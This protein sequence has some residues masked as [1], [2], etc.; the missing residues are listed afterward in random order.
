MCLYS[1]PSYRA[2]KSHLLC[3]TSC[4]HPWPVWIYHVFP[5]YLIKGNTFGKHLLNRREPFDFLS[6]FCLK[7]FSSYEEIVAILSY[8]YIDLLTPWCRVLLEKLTGLQ[9]VKK[10]PAFHGNR[11]FITA[12][13][14]FRHLSLSLCRMKHSFS[15][16]KDTTPPQPNH[17]VTP[18]HIEPE[19][20]NT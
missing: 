18:T 11:R 12:L 19:Q 9:L 6:N 17:T 10:F 7:H 16:H 15:L 5:R 13:T 3:A 20:Y 4:S 8:M 14:S 1:C 2:C